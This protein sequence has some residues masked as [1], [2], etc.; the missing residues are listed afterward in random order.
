MKTII[1]S[2]FLV[3]S[4][5]LFAQSIEGIWV[6]VDDETNK[7]KS[8]V[9]IY[10]KSDGKIYGKIIK[11]YRTPSQDQDPVCDKCTDDRKN[12]KIIG[13]DIIRG[14]SY[15]SDDKVWESGTIMDPAK[16]KEYKAKIWLDE[17]NNERL[18]V[19]G[20]V[21]FFY[22]TQTWAKVK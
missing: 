14:L 19:R 22:R 17:N 9:Q 6:T 10:K 16:G 20:Y 21:G 11:L 7:K 3:F 2:I 18:Q 4:F 13:M 5:G 12:K 15:T 8:L 1:L